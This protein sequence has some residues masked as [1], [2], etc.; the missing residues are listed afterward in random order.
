MK[1]TWPKLICLVLLLFSLGAA[2]TN[3]QARLG[4]EIDVRCL[5]PAGTYTE[6]GTLFPLVLEYHNKSLA[7]QMFELKWSLDELPVPREYKKI[8]LE[9][10]AKKRIP[11]LLP[12]NM[13]N[14]LYSLEV[15]DQNVPVSV[16]SNS[17]GRVTG[18]LS[19]ESDSLDYLRSLQLV[20]NPYYNPTNNPDDEEYSTLQSLSNVDEEVFP[21]H[22]AALTPMKVL[23][24]YDLTALNLS[25]NQYRAI[26]N[27][28]R[29]GGELVVMSNGIP[30]E[31]R[32]SPLE[33]IMPI[34]PE[35]AVSGTKAV[36]SSGQVHP[37]AVALGGNPKE[38]IV[39]ERP[40]VNGKV[41][42]VTMPLL[43]TDILGKQKTIDVWRD[44]L[45]KQPTYN[46]GPHT[47]SMMNSIPELPRTKATW[48][49]IFV[50]LYGIIVGPVNL[51]ILRKKD[52]MLWSFVTVP[53]VAIFFAGSAY[54]INRYIRPSTP[55]LRE[56]GY[57]TI[58][59]EQPVGFAES[60]Q[61]LFSP[62]SQDF[63]FSCDDAT[64]FEIGNN[65]W[66]PFG[67][68]RDFG[69]YSPTT[70]GGLQSTLK[71]GT[72]DIQRFQARTSLKMK[73][74]FQ[75]KL[76]SDEVVEIDSPLGSPA[77]TVYLPASGTSE[78]FELEGGRH[79]YKLKFTG[80]KP[81]KAFQFDEDLFPGREMLLDQVH[82]TRNATTGKLYFYSDKLQTPLDISD[83]TLY[84]HDYLICVEF[85]LD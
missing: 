59:A 77:A 19:T 83:G 44:I 6:Y 39:F 52:K 76:V 74:P 58:E 66:G 37:D 29:Q 61:L 84:K 8:V 41:Y 62:D 14:Q 36:R 42:Y 72:W 53:L 28:V 9:P 13:I 70:S 31:Y 24:C 11:F 26:V 49:A 25:D 73:S 34:K 18:I 3:G 51:T 80:N 78:P 55:V 7:P 15:N 47:F 57:M 68:S 60:E 65:R 67:V 63:H 21:E 71:M 35:F 75:L 30:T 12:P 85:D 23:I 48:V 40:I 10:G 4:R 5:Y 69:L 82:N 46:S 33:E 27:W 1:K 43:D 64:L 45:D 32:G 2:Q 17:Q 54:V 20:K 16:T 38:Q 81:S 50:L 22:W 56:L 79:T